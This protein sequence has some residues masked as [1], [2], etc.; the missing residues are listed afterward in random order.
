MITGMRWIARLVAVSPLLAA[1]CSPAPQPA[2]R[3][4]PG[5]AD[6]DSA[7][8]RIN[9]EVRLRKLHLVRPDLIP[10]PVAYEVYC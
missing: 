9:P 7:T 4:A 3:P 10:Y 6:P 5:A 2:A 1:L 8:T